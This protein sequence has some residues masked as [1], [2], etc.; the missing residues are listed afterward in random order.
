MLPIQPHPTKR[1]VDGGD[2]A[3]S[4]S[5]FLAS[6]FS[7]SQAFSQPAPPPLTQ[8]VGRLAQ[9]G[10]YKTMKK[11]IK[12]W[13]PKSRNPVSIGDNSQG[14]GTAGRFPTSQSLKVGV[15]STIQKRL[16]FN[17]MSSKSSI[18]SSN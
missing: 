4:T 9:G 15:S 13:Q 6:G 3:A 17:K 2:S 16:V 8:T 11:D 12:Q 5:I 1:A 10:S 14:N 7:C 18:V